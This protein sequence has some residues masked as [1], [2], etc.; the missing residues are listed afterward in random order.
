MDTGHVD[1]TFYAL[2]EPHRLEIVE[3]LRVRPMLVGEIVTKTKMRQ[4]QV[5]KHL[6]V[7]SEAGLVEKDAV[8]QKRIYKLKT[9]PLKELNA[10]LE[11]YRECWEESLDRLDTHLEKMKEGEKHGKHKR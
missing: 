2:A 8:A 10:W 11:H 1:W 4:P 9:T 3:L 7:L 5:S 6:K